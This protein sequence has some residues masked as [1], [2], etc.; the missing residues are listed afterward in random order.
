M[1][2]GRARTRKVAE[3]CAGAVCRAPAPWIVYA[4]E[5]VAAGAAGRLLLD[6]RAPERYRGDAEPIDPRA[7]H[8]PGAKSAP[9]SANLTAAPIPV[10]LPPAA[11]RKKYAALGADATPPVVYCGSGVTA[12]HDLLALH[13]RA[14]RRALRGLVERVERRPGGPVATGATP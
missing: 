13:A 8:I 12:C 7:G 14:C 4:Q 11:L 2:E 9:F 6:A 5:D 3:P 1:A 10:F